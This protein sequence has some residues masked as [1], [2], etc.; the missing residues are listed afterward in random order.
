MSKQYISDDY[1]VLA[2]LMSKE[3]NNWHSLMSSLGILYSNLVRIKWNEFYQGYDNKP[4]L[5]PTYPW[6]RKHSWVE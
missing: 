6:Q 2:P 3:Q 1:K 4:I 5:L